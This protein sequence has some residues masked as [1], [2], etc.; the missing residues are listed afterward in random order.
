MGSRQWHGPYWSRDEHLVGIRKAMSGRAQH[1]RRCASRGHT[2]CVA[3]Q[4]TLSLLQLAPW[5]A[6][7]VSL[8]ESFFSSEVITELSK[9]W[10]GNARACYTAPSWFL[11]L[12]LLTCGSWRSPPR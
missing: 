3:N 2:F 7:S 5:R 1:W 6:R 10:R 9:G 4:R 11:E 12:T 8:K